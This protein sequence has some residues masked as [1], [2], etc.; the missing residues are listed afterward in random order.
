MYNKRCSHRKNVA[1]LLSEALNYCIL[2]FKICFPPPFTVTQH[3]NRSV[4]SVGSYLMSSTYFCPVTVHVSVT[5]APPVDS[6]G[7]QSHTLAVGWPPKIFGT[8]SSIADSCMCG[9]CYIVYPEYSEVFNFAAQNGVF[10]VRLTP[11]K[12][13]SK[14]NRQVV[15]QDPVYWCN[16]Y[17]PTVNLGGSSAW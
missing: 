14:V 17:G 10:E 5:L 11:D 2:F 9:G 12:A 4:Q 15:L 16:S 8:R 6:A 1:Q 13:H 7:A 3:R